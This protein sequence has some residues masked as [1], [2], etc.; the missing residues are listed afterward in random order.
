MHRWV[1]YYIRLLLCFYSYYIC[2]CGSTVRRGMPSPKDQI[3]NEEK[4]GKRGEFHC[5]VW[6][7][8]CI[9]RCQRM[10]ISVQLTFYFH[11]IGY[12]YAMLAMKALISTILRRFEI[13]TSLREEDLIISVD[14][15]ARSTNGFPIKFH[16]KN[17]NFLCE[18]NFSLE[19]LN[20]ARITERTRINLCIHCYATPQPVHHVK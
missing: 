13:T 12:K 10:R 16:Q 15:L 4:R 5:T 18:L 19:R 8:A 17:W 3:Y 2:R 14:I 11:A 9:R 7:R 1:N 20:E 6:I